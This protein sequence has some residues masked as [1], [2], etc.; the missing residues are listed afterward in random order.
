FEL[1]ATELLDLDRVR[2]PATALRRELDVRVT[3]V[4][5]LRQ[6]ELGVPAA[7]GGHHRG[8]FRDL[9]AA[10]I[11]HLVLDARHALDRTDVAVLA[12][13]DGAQPTLER[14]LLA[15]LVDLAIVDDVPRE[16]LAARLLRPAA[17]LVVPAVLRDE[18]GV[19]TTRRE[20][21]VRAF[22]AGG[23]ERNR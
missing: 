18:R 12:V 23:A 8:A 15:R 16:A 20:Q 7:D 10:R 3:E 2:V 1:G 6:R 13:V 9:V 21:E 4:R 11:A 14:D 17:V 19:A 22:D 5:R